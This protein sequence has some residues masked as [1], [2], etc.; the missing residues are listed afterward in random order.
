MVTNRSVPA[1]TVLPHITYGNVAAASAWLIDAFGFAEHYRYGPPAAPS[2]AQLYLGDAWVMLDAADP[3]NGG[4]GAGGAGVGGGVGRKTPAELGYATQSLTVFVVDVDEHYQRA[5]LAGA[6]IVEDL[7][8]TMYGER[9]Y[10][11]RDLDGHHWL[12]S[13]HARDVSPAEWGATVTTPPRSQQPD[14]SRPP[15]S[16]ACTVRAGG[17][18]WCVLQAGSA[19]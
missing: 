1:S 10:G 13:A 12:F 2:G 5:K 16:G 11:V 9:Q 6:I 18:C 19:P 7:H 4:A 14:E 3:G 17:L 15:S 8:E